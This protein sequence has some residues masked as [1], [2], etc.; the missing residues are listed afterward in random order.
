ML[1]K[2][3]LKRT[4]I[5]SVLALAAF[6]GVTTA[7]L[8]AQTAD[9]TRIE[10]EVLAQARDNIERFRKSDAAI[11]IRNRDGQ[12]L[13]GVR[14]EVNQVT[15]DFLFGNLAFELAEPDA[16]SRPHLNAFKDRFKALFNYAIL[17]F[18]WSAYEASQGKPQWE[19]IQRAIDW[20]RSNGI[21]LKGHPLG[22]THPAGTPDWF[23]DLPRDTAFK[24]YEARI[25]NTVAGFKDDVDIWDVV[26]EPVNTIPMDRVFATGTNRDTR[27][28]EGARYDVT[29]VTT[30]DIVPWVADSFKWAAEA[31]P[32]GTFILN[33]FNLVPLPET[34]ERFAALVQTLLARGAPVR[35]L[36]IQAHEPR[37]EWFP[38]DEV[39]ATLDRLAQF[40]LP[41]HITEFI[42]QSSGK[43]ITGGWRE[44]PWTAEAQ[45]DFAEQFYTI[46]FGHPAVA[47]INWWGLSDAD[48]WLPGGGLLDEH[49][50]PKPAYDRLLKLIKHDW[51]TKNLALATDKG[52]QATFRGFQGGYTIIASLPD[53]TRKTL[54]VHVRANE[55]NHWDF[56]L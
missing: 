35:G 14:L 1:S 50:E 39:K 26:N 56:R 13:A 22:W 23:L 5:A 15:Q 10:Q 36:G 12:P 47:T 11:T 41:L 4:A 33:E 48:I 31:N 45:A 25:R 2:S 6:A 43:P 51:M 54:T 29:G 18:Y 44:G 46:A 32:D 30:D 3:S 55:E 19:R 7:S 28:G 24:L 38:P 42:P 20:C 49:Y 52:G 8:R 9:H 16:A 34:R 53:G 17:P 27:I 21:T 40:G 37:E